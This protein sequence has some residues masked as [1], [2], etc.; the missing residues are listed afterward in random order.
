[1][2]KLILV[3]IV[4]VFGSCQE[5]SDW[6]LNG[7]YYEIVDGLNN[8]ILTT[9]KN[10]SGFCEIYS[11]VREHINDSSFLLVFQTPLFENGKSNL[12]SFLNT[13]FNAQKNGYKLKESY[14]QN[15]W[16]NYNDSINELFIKK[17]NPNIERA[18]IEF[19]Y[20]T[21][22]IVDSL[23][24]NNPFHKKVLEHNKNYWIIDLKI[25]SLYG[26]YQKQEYLEQ[27]IKLGVNK[28]LK[29]DAE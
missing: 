10:K 11:T 5:P 25:D 27:K 16:G 17:D 6:E 24:K 7:K 3:Y 19:D 21:Q 20:K 18:T 28:K 15:Y 13:R 29:L 9:W 14:Q 12:K 23:V 4:F 1:M 22:L 2:K 26:P 8:R